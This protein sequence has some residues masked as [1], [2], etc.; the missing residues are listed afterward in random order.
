MRVDK[1]PLLFVTGFFIII[2]MGK[3]LYKQG[4]R[5]CYICKEIKT[6]TPE[7]FYPHKSK[8]YRSECKVCNRKLLDSI[9][10][11]LAVLTALGLKCKKCHIENKNP[12]FF[13]IDHIIPVRH[14]GR[15]RR[16]SMS[17]INNYMVLC[18]N[19]HRIKTLEENGFI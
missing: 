11:R 16:Y 3:H 14:G 7:N 1:T 10:R 18:P 8:G 6:I 9:P 2:V 17:Q 5:R 4:L 19:C 15:G 13:D 12:S